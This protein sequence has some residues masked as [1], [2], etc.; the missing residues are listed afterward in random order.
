MTRV[1][2]DERSSLEGGA[3]TPAA[4]HRDLGDRLER[5]PPGHP[6]SPYEADG[7]RRQAVPRLRDLDSFIDDEPDG[8]AASKSQPDA[9]YSYD[10]TDA[11]KI[12]DNATAL[13][14][15]EQPPHFADADWLVRRTE[16]RSILDTAHDTKQATD[17]QHTVDADNQYYTEERSIAHEG[18]IESIYASAKD[19]PNQFQAIIAGGL[20]GAGKTTI[21]E[22]HAGIDRSQ[23]LTIAPD[24]IKVEL[25]ER[26]LLPQI[27]GLSPMET[28][29]LA[30]VE[31]SYIARQLA[32]RAQA[33]GKNLI[34]D[35]TMSSKKTTEQRIEN[36]RDDGYTNIAGIFVDVPIEVSLARADARHRSGQEA[37]EAGKGLG[38]RYMPPDAILSKADDEWGSQNRRAFEELKPRFDRW[39]LY[40]NSVEWRDPVVIDS[41]SRADKLQGD[42]Q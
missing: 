4:P 32:Q 37:F 20:A 30:H 11:T 9:S 19:V 8:P 36:L 41:S 5:L 26:G 13:I 14:K 42:N 31:S 28:A 1:P 22:H 12:S 27:D 16:S 38:G 10:A 24:D 34:W 3:D 21:L 15:D 7:T 35:I 33:D 29:D 39:V 23:Y 25:A 18:I 2:G 6:S 17:E 40:D